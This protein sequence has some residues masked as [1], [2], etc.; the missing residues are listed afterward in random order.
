MAFAL[1]YIIKII[2][3]LIEIRMIRLFFLFLVEISPGLYFSEIKNNGFF[4]VQDKELDSFDDKYSKTS[5]AFLFQAGAKYYITKNINLHVALGYDFVGKAKVEDFK[6]KE[7]MVN[8]SGIR[9]TGGVG[10][11]F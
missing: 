3:I 2:S 5:F 10:F 4:V 11:S 8:W 1:E 6:P 7:A 9:F